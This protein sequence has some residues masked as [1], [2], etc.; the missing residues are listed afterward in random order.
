M[1]PL[2]SVV[3]RHEYDMSNATDIFRGTDVVEVLGSNYFH[4]FQGEENEANPDNACCRGCAVRSEG[5]R[6]RR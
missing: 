3:R 4:T 6:E 2:N 5:I 1:R